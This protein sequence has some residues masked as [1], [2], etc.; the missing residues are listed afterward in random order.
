[1]IR[2][3]PLC[4]QPTRRHRARAYFTI[5]FISIF[6]GLFLAMMIPVLKTEKIPLLFL[7]FSPM[8]IPLVYYFNQ[9]KTQYHMLDSGVTR[10]S[11]FRSKHIPWEQ[12]GELQFSTEGKNDQY[13]GQLGLSLGALYGLFIG[14]I[15]A[16][17]QASLNGPGKPKKRDQVHKA[18]LL[19]RNGWT[20]M[21]IPPYL[22]P[23]F[24]KLVISRAR[25]Q[26]IAVFES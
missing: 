4:A 12:V 24:A 5:S 22:T 25:S 15:V 23:D 21:T 11:L 16:L 9:A 3:A 18:R 19:D 2:T 13:T 10:K 20:L 7:Y 8:L 17:V 1:M 6:V 26:G 14:V